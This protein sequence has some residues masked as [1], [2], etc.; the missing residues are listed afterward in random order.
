MAWKPSPRC[1]SAA[2]CSILEKDV[3][4]VPSRTPDDVDGSGK[5]SN[6]CEEMWNLTL[7]TRNLATHS[8]FVSGTA[9]GS[10]HPTSFGKLT[11]YK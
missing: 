4:I 9:Y 10:L 7:E 11:S 1:V 8:K 6:L 2:S 3:S 5:Q